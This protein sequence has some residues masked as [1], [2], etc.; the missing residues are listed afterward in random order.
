[1]PSAPFFSPK[2]SIKVFLTRNWKRFAGFL[3][4]RHGGQTQP[5]FSWRH[6]DQGEDSPNRKGVA[7]NGRV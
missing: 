1:V 3:F 5:A 6:P 2:T 4:A 7:G